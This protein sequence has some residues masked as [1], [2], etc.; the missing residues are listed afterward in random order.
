MKKIIITADDYGMSA[1]VNK[2]IDEG[3]E[4]GI[5][6]STNV[7]T[8][9][10]FYH[11][12]SKLKNTN[13]SV[14]L[15]WNLTCGYPVLSRTEIKSLVQD[16]GEFYGY[17]DF[18]NRF[19]QGMIDNEDIAKE[20]RAQYGL[21][22]D[23]MGEPDYWNTHENCHVD[24][25]IYQLFVSTAQDLNIKKMRS[26]QRIYVRPK[27]GKGSYSLKWKIIEPIK[28]RILDFWQNDAHKKGIA[29]PDGRVCCLDSSDWHDMQYII[30]NI[31]W[32]GKTI[33]EFAFHPAT[34]CDSRFFGEMTDSRIAE[35]AIATDKS[36]LKYISDAGIQL[37]NFDSV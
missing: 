20:L 37:V 33:G 4:C 27:A 17:S 34:E 7:M 10:P 30:N 9:M 11:D 36:V 18:R 25:K 6:T 29:S 23:L 21:F 16:N 5:I 2:A 32:K 22:Y 19:R 28:A 15:H 12:A 1:A 31:G 13:A 8:N 26:H 3:I 14:G 35:Y 24:F